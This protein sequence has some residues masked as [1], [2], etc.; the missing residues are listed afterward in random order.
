MPSSGSSTGA[1]LPASTEPARRDPDGA[2]VEG[3]DLGPAA[4]CGGD[5]GSGVGPRGWSPGLTPPELLLQAPPPSPPCLSPFVLWVLPRG[6]VRCEQCWR[7]RGG[8]SH[9]T[10]AAG[11]A[12]IPVRCFS[13]A[14]T[15]QPPRGRSVP[16]THEQGGRHTCDGGR[17]RPGPTVQLQRVPVAAGFAFQTSSSSRLAGPGHRC[18]HGHAPRS[19]RRGRSRICGDG[20]V[21]TGGR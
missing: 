20:S 13:E 10:A 11:R 4:G 21:V 16:P 5:A 7:S 2:A 6:R 18:P 19:G 14:P 17:G 9:P 15:L 8:V 1:V 3:G 12:V